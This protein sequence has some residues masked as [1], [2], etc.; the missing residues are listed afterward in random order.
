MFTSECSQLNNRI[1]MSEHTN[2]KTMW[3]LTKGQQTNFTFFEVDKI[4][5][6]KKHLTQLRGME[7]LRRVSSNYRNGRTPSKRTTHGNYTADGE[8]GTC[9]QYSGL[10]TEMYPLTKKRTRENRAKMRPVRTG[11]LQD[12][13]CRWCRVPLQTNY[14]SGKTGRTLLRRKRF[15]GSTVFGGTAPNTWI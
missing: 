4:S 13:E 12:T 11:T 5:V 15:H 9:R 6:K 7:N 8:K 14:L 10:G 1:R 2:H 3:Q